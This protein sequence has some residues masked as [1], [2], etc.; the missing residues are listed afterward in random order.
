MHNGQMPVSGQMNIQFDPVGCT[1][2]REA[3]G[4]PTVL[5]GFRAGTSVRND[6]PLEFLKFELINFCSA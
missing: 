4:L 5:Q 6:F 2:Y 3:K 1:I